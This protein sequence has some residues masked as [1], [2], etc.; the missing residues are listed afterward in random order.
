M[1]IEKK[2][3]RI[4]LTFFVLAAMLISALAITAEYSFAITTTKLPNNNT[5]V[6]DS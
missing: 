5:R 2:K 6:P 1:S 4:V 3:T